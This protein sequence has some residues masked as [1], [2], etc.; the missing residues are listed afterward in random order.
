MLEP[1][2]VDSSLMNPRH[3][4]I[5]TIG[6]PHC[7]SN[8]VR[9]YALSSSRLTGSWMR[10]TV[11]NLAEDAQEVRGAAVPVVEHEFGRDADPET[12]EPLACKQM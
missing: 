12:Q 9:L 8:L 1:E 4:G 6:I 11:S 7:T 10:L 2:P 3:A 5:K